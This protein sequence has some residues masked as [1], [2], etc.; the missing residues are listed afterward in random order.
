[1]LGD[2][3]YQASGQTIGRRVLP[4]QGGGPR[5]EITFHEAGK[6]LGVD[7]D[8]TGTYVNVMRP[9]GSLFGEGQGIV[10][11]KDGDGITWVGQGVGRIGQDGAISFR[12]AI[13]FQTAS[14]KFARLNSVA[15][16]YEHDIE[17]NGAHKGTYWEWK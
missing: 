6:L 9:D 1:M 12:G 8:N 15:T 11:S 13:Y 3:L 10:M 14:S 16:V 7:V 2:Q 17:P 4:S 5:M